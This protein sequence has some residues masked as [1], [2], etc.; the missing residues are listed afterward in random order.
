MKYTFTCEDEYSNWKNSTEFYAESLDEVL[1][2][3]G[4]FLKG[5]TFYIDGEIDIVNT[6]IRISDGYK[7]SPS[8]MDFIVKSLSSWN[9]E[10]KKLM[11]QPEKCR[12]CGFALDIM[13]RH[14]CYQPGCPLAKSL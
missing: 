14:D 13:A 12:V 11:S 7:E 10:T 3:F 4:Y 6:D 9:E 5:S 1:E 8:S 2:N